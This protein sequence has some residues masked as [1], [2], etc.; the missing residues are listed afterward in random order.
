MKMGDGGFRLAYNVQ[1]ATST[2]KKVIVGV[3]VVNTLDPGTLVSMMQQVKENLEEIECPNPSKWLADSAYANKDDAEQA[4]KHFPDTTLYSPPTGNGK[5][6]AL[7]PRK[8]DNLA[9]IEL[10]KRM[11]LI[12]YCG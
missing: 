10:R 3:E 8:N 2:D 5:V 11:I 4:E 12:G 1:F 6:D 9:M 7:T